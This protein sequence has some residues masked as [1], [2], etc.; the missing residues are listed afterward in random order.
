MEQDNNKDVSKILKDHR[1][2]ADWIKPAEEKAE[3][4]KAQRKE[5]SPA[6][7]YGGQTPEEIFD[8]PAP[9]D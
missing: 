8:F 6:A 7:S 3:D 4:K 9:T 5:E 2:V 1:A